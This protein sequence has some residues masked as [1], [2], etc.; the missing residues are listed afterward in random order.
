MTM[1]KYILDIYIYLILVKYSATLG[2]MK[3]FK[4]TFIRQLSIFL[5]A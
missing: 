5:T 2:F 3:F 4:T 1:N